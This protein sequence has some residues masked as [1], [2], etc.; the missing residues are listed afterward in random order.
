MSKRSFDT[1]LDEYA[2]KFDEAFPVRM[3]PSDEKEVMGIIE[4]CLKSN[5]PYDPYMEEDIDPE[6]DY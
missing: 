6:A 5:T 4:R 1:L 3:A 2:T